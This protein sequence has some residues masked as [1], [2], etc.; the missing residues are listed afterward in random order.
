MAIDYGKKRTG[1]A[2]TDPLQIIATGLETVDSKQIIPYLKKYFAAEQVELLLLGEP[3]NW[4][5][6]PTH[7]TPLVAAFKKEFIK[8]F[9]SIPVIGVDERNTSKMARQSM[10]ESGMKKKQRQIKENVDIVAATMMLQE[11]LQWRT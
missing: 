5:G 3:L 2:V 7:A 4:D 6:F 10:V 8:N 9:P 1:I 11:Y